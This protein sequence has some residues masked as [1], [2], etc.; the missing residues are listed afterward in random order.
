MEKNA[1]DLEKLLRERFSGSRILLA[2]DESV[3]RE[4]TEALLVDVGLAVD[5]AEDGVEAIRRAGQVRY[6]AILMDVVMPNMDGLEATRRIRKLYEYDDIPII[7]LTANAFTEDQ[8]KCFSAGMNDYLAKPVSYQ[9]LYA[10]LL[11][12]LAHS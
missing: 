3:N 9:D 5:L 6:T 12:W 1:S 2:E 4:V 10:I 7:A 11:K 8:P